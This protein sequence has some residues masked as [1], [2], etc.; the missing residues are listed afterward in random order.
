MPFRPVHVLTRVV[1]TS[2]AVDLPSVHIAFPPATELRHRAVGLK[3]D[4]NPF[5]LKRAE[6]AACSHDQASPR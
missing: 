3:L 1:P 5:Q 6:A 4:A 2:Q